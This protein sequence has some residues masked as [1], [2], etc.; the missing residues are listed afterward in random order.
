MVRAVVFDIGN[1]L[2]EWQPERYYDTIM[3]PEERREMFAAVDLH[4]MNDVI[5]RGGPFRETIYAEADKHPRWREAIRLWHDDWIRLAS[6]VIPHSLRLLR[7]LRAKAVPV[8]ALSNFGIGSFAYARTQYA[9]LDEF[10]RTWIS[11]RMGVIKPDAKIYALAEA[12]CGLAPTELLF[13]D[14]RAEN[15]AAAASRGWGTHL[16]VGPEGWAARLVAE[17]LLSE[18]DAA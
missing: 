10:D 11:G 14:D 9:F 18:E 7:A 12:D 15:I 5:D 3:T 13:T 8:F 16:F 4:G 1:V 2:I 6:P 17:G